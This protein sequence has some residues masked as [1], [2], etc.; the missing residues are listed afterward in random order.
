MGTGRLPR[1]VSSPREGGRGARAG[2]SVPTLRRRG[3]RTLRG[4]GGGGGDE[5]EGE[6][7]AA[8]LGNGNGGGRGQKIRRGGRRRESLRCVGGVGRTP[9]HP[10]TG[11]FVSF[12]FARVR[13]PLSP[14]TALV[15]PAGHPFILAW[16]DGNLPRS[17]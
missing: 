14:T 6:L 9:S 13:S 2:R 12:V 17:L 1:G 16:L 15:C 5:R 7:P 11:F 3:G 4:G 10:D 8:V